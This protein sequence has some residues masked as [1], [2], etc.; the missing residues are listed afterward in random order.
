MTSR[1]DAS[2]IEA[3]RAKLG[4]LFASTSE[5]GALYDGVCRILTETLTTYNWVGIYLVEGPDLVL[6][7][8]RGPA[9]TEHVRIPVGTGICGA[10]AAQGQTIVVPDVHA[11]PRY[12]QCFLETRSEI[13]VPIVHGDEVLG[14][15]DVDSD[16]LDAF[17]L[18]DQELLEWAAAR[19]ASA[20]AVARSRVER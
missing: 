1:T 6:A 4:E 11:D 14:E 16:Q 5:L 2:A 8:W 10:A 19:L 18:A 9:P 20:L 7:A 3:A 12:L 15:I 17:G 13:V